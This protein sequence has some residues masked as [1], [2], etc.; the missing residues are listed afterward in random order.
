MDNNK[1]TISTEKSTYILFSKQRGSPRIT[2]S[3]KSIKSAKSFKYLRVYLDDKFNW[4]DHIKIQADK[5]HKLLLNLRKIAGC[6]WEI[7][8]KQRRIL[9]KTVAE[10]TL[11]YG[12]A[13]W[14]PFTIC[15]IGQC[16][17]FKDHSSFPL[18]VPIAPHHLQ[19]SK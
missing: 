12:A 6:N 14:R 9:Y 1:L 17:Q 2:W 16:L 5:E 19:L 15:K 13:A 11:D 10:R 8:R 4:S 7:N 3:N 18:Q